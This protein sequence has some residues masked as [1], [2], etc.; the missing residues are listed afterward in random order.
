MTFEEISSTWYEVL[1]GNCECFDPNIDTPPMFDFFPG[2]QES[3]IFSDQSACR[4][5]MLPLRNRPGLIKSYSGGN[6][7]NI[8]VNKPFSNFPN[9]D[10][11]GTRWAPTSFK[12]SYYPYKKGEITPVTHFFSAIHKGG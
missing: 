10:L 5:P 7:V 6:R 12:W 1:L 3:L 8:S 4:S 11:G 2:Q 9:P